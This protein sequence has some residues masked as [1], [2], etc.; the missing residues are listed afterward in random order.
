LK[1]ITLYLTEFDLKRLDDLV[2]NGIYPNRAEAI[3][4]AVHDLVNAELQREDETDKIQFDVKET[5]LILRENDR[6]FEIE[7]MRDKDNSIWGVYP[8]KPQ[9][10]TCVFADGMRN[11]LLL[12]R[13]GFLKLEDF[14]RKPTKKEAQ[15]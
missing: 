3:R 10:D 5:A 13:K 12:S 9:D 11:I 6:T 7:I 4:F 2:K 15:S 8:E 14:P 1:L